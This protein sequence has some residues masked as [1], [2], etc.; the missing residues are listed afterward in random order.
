M[1]VATMITA[2]VIVIAQLPANR[3]RDRLFADIAMRGAFDQPFFEQPSCTLFEQTDLQGRA[4]NVK[5]F[6][7]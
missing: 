6:F 2:D 5:Q 3:G 7:G 1:P 4:V